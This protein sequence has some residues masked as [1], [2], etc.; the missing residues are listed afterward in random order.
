MKVSVR[1]HKSILHREDGLWQWGCVRKRK[2][3]PKKMVAKV[4][5][6]NRC[7]IL[8]EIFLSQHMKLSTQKKKKKREKKIK[9]SRC[10]GLKLKRSEK[11]LEKSSLFHPRM[12]LHKT[13]RGHSRGTKGMRRLR[14]ESSRVFCWNDSIP[15]S[16]WAF[17]PSA[18]HFRSDF[19]FGADGLNDWGANK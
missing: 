12:S 4:E 8:P 2:T 9:S 3:T 15:S 11:F 6:G 17:T 13:F 16:G 14:R 5:T 1:H 10:S 18:S 19:F 7:K